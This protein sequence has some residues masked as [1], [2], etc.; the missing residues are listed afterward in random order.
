MLFFDDLIERGCTMHFECNKTNVNKISSRILQGA[1][2][3]GEKE[4]II[5]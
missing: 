4:K 3:V 1:L 5:Y 2:Q